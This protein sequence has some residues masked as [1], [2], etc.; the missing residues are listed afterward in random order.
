M[1]D[2]APDL[3]HVHAR[4]GDLLAV[5]RML[6]RVDRLQ[7]VDAAKQRRL[8]RAGRADQADH[9]VLVHRQVDALQHLQLAERLVD[10]RADERRVG[11][12]HT[13]PPACCRLRSRATSQSVNRACGTVIST[14]KNAATT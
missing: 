6:P 8:A 12:A 2:P 10:V 1:P 4:R 5:D 7:Q 11:V 9:L 13:R 3:V 14:K